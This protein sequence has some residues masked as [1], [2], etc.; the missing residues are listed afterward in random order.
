ML[1]TSRMIFIITPLLILKANAKL[2][3]KGIKYSRQI[4]EIIDNKTLNILI[5]VQISLLDPE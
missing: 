2:P 4:I 1:H 5:A 3:V